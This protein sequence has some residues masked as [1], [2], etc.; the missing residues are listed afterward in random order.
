MSTPAQK[1]LK[2]I[3]DNEDYGPKLARLNRTDER[4][5]LDLIDQNKMPEARKLII[6]LDRAR[7]ERNNLRA[8]LRRFMDKDA[9]ERS[10]MRRSGEMD[11]ETRAFWELYDGMMEAA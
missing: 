5:V 10:R 11:D 3:L 8:R 9:D 1:R 4:R 7:K 6:E 2:R